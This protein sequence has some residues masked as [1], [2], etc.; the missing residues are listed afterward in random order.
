MSV[1]DPHGH[2]VRLPHLLYD[3]A[4]EAVLLNYGDHPDPTVALTRWKL[5]AVIA[6]VFRC[7]WRLVDALKAFH[8][9][10]RDPGSPVYATQPGEEALEGQE[11]TVRAD[12]LWQPLRSWLDDPRLTSRQRQYRWKCFAMLSLRV[13]S[14]WKLDDIG[15]AW[16]QNKSRVYTS[17]QTVREQLASAFNV[18]RDI[19]IPRD[20][21]T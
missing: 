3:T 20:E 1:V 10:Q 14:A 5:L 7:N 4:F 15:K 8:P 19:V 11:L 16:G 9:V 21:G 18:D 13:T 6:L 2:Q 12:D 17:I